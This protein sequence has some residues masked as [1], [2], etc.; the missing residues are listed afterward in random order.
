MLLVSGQGIEEENESAH[1]QDPEGG[2]GQG[3][4]QAFEVSGL[5]DMRG[6]PLK[7]IAFQVAETSFVSE[8]P[9]VKVRDRL[10]K[11]AN[12]TPGF[13]I[14]DFPQDTNGLPRPTGFLEDPGTS[15]PA[16]AV[17]D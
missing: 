17:T 11:I 3:E 14:A 15:L 6:V 8:T 13:S 4:E 7:A 1:G 2:E 9:G 12:Q 5:P 10:G 16:L